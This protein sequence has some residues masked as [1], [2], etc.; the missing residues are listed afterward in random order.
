[1]NDIVIVERISGTAYS[2]R[3]YSQEPRVEPA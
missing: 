3:W 2:V 1:M